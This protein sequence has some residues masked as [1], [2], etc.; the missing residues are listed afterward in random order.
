[1]AKSPE[2]IIELTDILEHGPGASKKDATGD[3]VDLSFE[4]ELEDLFAESPEN[5]PSGSSPDIPGLDDLHLPD[6]TSAPGGDIDLDGLD[7]LL[8][9]A[10]KSRP[11]GADLP[12]LTEDFLSDLSEQAS[13]PSAT[14]AAG[15]AVVAAAALAAT[16]A[17]SAEAMDSLNARLDALEEK[18]AGMSDSLTDSFKAMLDDAVAG[19]KAELPAQ[20]EPPADPAPMIAELKQSLEEQIEALKAELPKPLNEEALAERIKQEILAALPGAPDTGESAVPMIEEATAR[21]P[22]SIDAL[23]SRMDGV[24]ADLSSLV[25]ELAAQLEPRIAALETQAAAGSPSQPGVSTDDLDALRQEVLADMKKAMPAA[26]AQV[27]REEIQT[28]LQEPD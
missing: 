26:A 4:R 13:P 11:G 28:L 15:T 2:D 9:D 24:P 27:I 19:I 10:D 5:K 23:Q 8:A 18:L 20:A 12:E 1:M 22:G 17:P 3:G 7:A 25:D 6:E 21:L 16:A 14:T